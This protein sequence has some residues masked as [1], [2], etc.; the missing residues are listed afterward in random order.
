MT[1]LQVPT[2]PDLHPCRSWLHAF[3]HLY[4]VALGEPSRLAAANVRRWNELVALEAALPRLDRERIVYGVK[5]RMILSLG[6]V[7]TKYSVYAI[8]HLYTDD[9]RIRLPPSNRPTKTSETAYTA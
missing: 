3:E 6:Y 7:Q 5:S 8:C 4:R 1:R 2:G 9:Y